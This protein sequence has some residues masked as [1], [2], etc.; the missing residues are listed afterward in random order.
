MMR[1]P[2][3]AVSSDNAAKYDDGRIVCQSCGF[4]YGEAA[5]FDMDQEATQNWAFGAFGEKNVG[6][7][8]CGA[9]WI[10][11]LLNPVDGHWITLRTQVTR[12]EM[13]AAFKA[14]GGDVR[15]Q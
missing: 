8:W 4:E 1:C 3:C 9:D 11:Q 13:I 14:C 15:D 10:R 12:N 5:M 6:N 2:G 7:Q